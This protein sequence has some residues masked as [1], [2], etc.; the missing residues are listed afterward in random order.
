LF[1][2]VTYARY[3]STAG[4]ALG[5]IVDV[6]LLVGEEVAEVVGDV[7]AVGFTAT[8]TPPQPA[9]AKTVNVN[10]AAIGIRFVNA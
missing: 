6:G 7:V 8:S 10:T 1:E 4:C 3:A 9:V 5:S 2:A